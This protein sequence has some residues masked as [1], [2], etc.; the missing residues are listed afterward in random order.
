MRAH[1][2]YR[3]RT[4]KAYIIDSRGKTWDLYDPEYIQKYADGDPE[5]CGWG[6]IQWTYPDRKKGLLEYAKSKGKG[7]ISYFGDMDTQ[8]EYLSQELNELFKDEFE[9]FKRYEKEKE[10]G[11]ATIFFRDQIEKT[12]SDSDQIRI[13]AAKNI[14]EEYIKK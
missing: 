3:M 10:L 2:T 9:M 7:D 6:L 14:L 13:N 12:S 1:P 11:E 4:E 8:L 5:E